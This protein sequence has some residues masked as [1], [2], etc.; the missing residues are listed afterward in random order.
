VN[1]WQLAD[2]VFQ[3]EFPDWYFIMVGGDLNDE[4]YTAAQAQITA[5]LNLQLTLMKSIR[6]LFDARLVDDENNKII[7]KLNLIGV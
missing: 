1:W 7:H 2:A 5:F 6:F 4:L 3:T